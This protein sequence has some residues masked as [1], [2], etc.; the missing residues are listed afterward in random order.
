MFAP[1]K[2]EFYCSFHKRQYRLTIISFLDNI[3]NMMTSFHNDATE[4]VWRGEFTKKLP[5]QIQAVARRSAQHSYQRSMSD[6]FCVEC[7]ARGTC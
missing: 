2:L 6:V 3:R 1:I 5:N 4:S 7:L